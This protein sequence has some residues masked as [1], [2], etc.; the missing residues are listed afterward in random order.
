MSAVPR[1]AEAAAG[2]PAAATDTEPPLRVTREGAVARITLDLARCDLIG[3]EPE[4]ARLKVLEARTLLDDADEGIELDLA[5]ADLVDA[6]VAKALGD[7]DRAV[8]L[9]RH[10]AEVTEKFEGSSE[11]A[12]VWASV[13]EL[14]RGVDD[15]L[16]LEAM[17]R[18]MAAGGVRPDRLGTPH[19]PTSTPG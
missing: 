4:P 19:P 6:H 10:A 9:G 5:L 17:T 2:V 14:A 7:T 8:I 16:C 11:V 1:S 12:R 18:S 13:A 15:G 3:G